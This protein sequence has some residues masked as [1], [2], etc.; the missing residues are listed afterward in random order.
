MVSNKSEYMKEYMKKYISSSE[1]IK[2]D[3]GGKYKG[4]RK[5]AHDKTKRHINFHDKSVKSSDDVKV[6]ESIE[7]LKKEIALL[8]DMITMSKHD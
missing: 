8:K 5:Y 6:A 4:Y 3:C 7:D 1:D 2:C